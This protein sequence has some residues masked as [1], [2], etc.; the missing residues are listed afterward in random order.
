M[1]EQQKQPFHERV[2]QQLIEQ[3]KEGTAPWQKPWQPGE[4]DFLPVNAAT[5]KRYKGVN[6]I[7][8]MAQGYDDNRWMTYKQAEG[9]GVQV[10]KG[11]KGTGV[12]YWKFEDETPVRDAQGKP[13]KTAEGEPVTTKV[14]LERPRAFYATV[15][16]ASQIDGLPPLPPFE[17]KPFTQQARVEQIMANSNVPIA[18][19]PGDRAYYRPVTD[20][21]VLPKRDQFTSEAG[22]YATALHELGHATGHPSRLDRTFGPRGSEAYARE[23]LRA[24]IASLIVGSELGTG[25]D[26]GQHAAYVGSWVKALEEQ[27]LEIMRACADAEKI[28][29]FVMTWEQQQTQAVAVPEVA[30]AETIIA[31][32]T[33]L[34]AKAN[35][36]YDPLE[37]WQT[38]SAAAAQVGLVATLERGDGPDPE[39]ATSPYRI[40][41]ATTEGAATSIVTSMFS[42]GKALTMVQGQRVPGTGYT[43]DSEWQTGQLTTAAGIERTSAA[44][45]IDALETEEYQ[46]LSIAA[47]R[48]ENEQEIGA[49]DPQCRFIASALARQGVTHQELFG[50]TIPEGGELTSDMAA[51]AV[52]RINSG[53]KRQ[54]E[55]RADAITPTGAA[56]AP[57][58]E[59]SEEPTYIRASYSDRKTV[60]E[61]GGVWDADH[62][63][64]FVPAGVDLA[65]FDRWR[66]DS[67][68]RP[69]AAPTPPDRPTA[70]REYIAVPY[71]D[72]EEAKA[73][74]AKW[75]RA[76]KCWYAPEGASPELATRFGT[77]GQARQ[78]SAPDPREE[79][80]QALKDIGCVVTGEHPIMDGQ[81]HRIPVD[82]DKKSER[83]G[84]YVGHLDGRPAGYIKNNRTQQGGD[85]KSTGTRLSAEQVAEL[86]AEAATKLQARDAARE[87]KTET[88]A[89]RC[90]TELATLRPVTSPTPYM[91]AKGI[92]PHAGV[93]TDTA[94]RRTFVPAY[95]IEGKQWTT[96]TIEHD[97][98]KRFRSN[99]RKEGC[100]HVI[101][102]Q[103]G[104]QA[105]PAIVIAEGYST[106]AT[107][108]EQLG[109]PTVAAFDAGNLKPVAEALS[110]AYPDKPI[111]IAGDDD[112]RLE[113]KKPF[114]N[115]GREKAKE[116][117]EA[118]SGTS[119]VPAFTQADRERGLSD[120]NDLETRAESTT[121]GA[122]KQ[123]EPIVRYEIERRSADVARS[124]TEDHAR[125]QRQEREPRAIRIRG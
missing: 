108:T 119:I 42:D 32:L 36:G 59:T 120:F 14:A 26:P 37:S 92:E 75:D 11:E 114:V 96:Q 90:Q 76:A 15:F 23:E 86:R 3:L 34:S 94:G 8:L 48:A 2:A 104:L 95:D 13:V 79:F 53:I 93:F 110:R 101:D 81:R 115:I 24:E 29:D 125:A 45:A 65:P 72:R 20:T 117:A 103:A 87:A 112:Y 70:K 62:K 1:A 43:S 60:R 109:F 52:A 63:S 40:T 46:R 68:A 107:L 64:W 123:I 38:L 71:T 66:G 106:A 113:A 5:G 80:A 85:W 83:S 89:D 78:E 116:A 57:A 44:E 33:A 31:E 22:F 9:E 88:V 55:T 69:T 10:R 82:G 17:A 16:N 30:E 56:V 47:A 50:A 98:S 73:L 4:I 118:V 58:Q 12:I 54:A 91:E 122:R 49:S 6:A 21:I 105:A 35:A 121:R 19:V 28:R 18:E 7:A 39:G 27:P 84:F 25:H 61:L 124:Q 67:E 97:G 77:G 74:G 111:I 41:Y 99:S 100:F 51:V 102:G